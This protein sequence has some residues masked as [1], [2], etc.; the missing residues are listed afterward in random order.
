M[1][2]ILYMPKLKIGQE[3]V[4]QVIPLKKNSFPL[5]L[6]LNGVTKIKKNHFPKYLTVLLAINLEEKRIFEESPNCHSVI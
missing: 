4:C 6:N 1:H 3:F 2:P 5:N